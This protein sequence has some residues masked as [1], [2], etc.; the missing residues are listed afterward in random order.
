VL[1]RVVLDVRSRGIALAPAPDQVVAGGDQGR[2]SGPSAAGWFVR[3]AGAATPAPP[4]SMLS[5]Q[6]RM[7]ADVDWLQRA[8][9]VRPI[10]DTRLV[11]VQAEHWSPRAAADI[12]NTLAKEF[13]RGEEENRR[14]E[15]RDRLSSLREQA[16]DVRRVIQSSENRLYGS[17]SSGLALAN[18]RSKQL[19]QS[20]IELSSGV[21]KA[22]SD[23]HVIDKQLARIAAFR[24][25]S[26]PDWSNPPVQTPAMDELYRELQRTETDILA[27]RRV[28]REGSQEL[29]PLE[30]QITALRDAMRREL[31]KAYSDLETQR[32]ALSARVAEQEQAIN[33]NERS[34]KT[35]SD[36][37]YKYSTLESELGTQRDLYTLLLKKVQEQDIAQTIMPATVDVVQAATVP[38]ESV[39]PRKV[40]NLA[41]GLLLGLVFG[42][43]LALALEAIRRTIRTPRD[44]VQLLQL[45]VMGM[46]P[47]R[48]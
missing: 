8:V 45:P 10:R 38:M 41:V 44:V 2:A 36:S 42:T 3:M 12:A 19:A 43:G 13:V 40:V 24:S 25:A 16:S 6:A 7:A 48:M 33:Y 20:G 27:Q 26:A 14:A 37:S 23:L 47:R 29:A 46:I 17:Q 39:R 5:A 9:S 18:E 35:L 21:L 15:D 30:A 1:E 34:I 28:Y 4:D 31:Q 11:D 22:R 32:E